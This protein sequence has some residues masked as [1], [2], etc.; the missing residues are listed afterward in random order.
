M[1][2]SGWTTDGKC[3]TARSR[4]G[5]PATF[6]LDGVIA[7]WTEGVQLMVEGEKTRF[8][9]P[10][11][12]AYKGQSAPYGH[13]GVRRRADSKKVQWTFRLGRCSGLR[14]RALVSCS[15]S[16]NQ[17]RSG[18]GCPARSR[19]GKPAPADGGSPQL[20][21]SASVCHRVPL[22]AIPRRT[23][24]SVARLSIRL[25]ETVDGMLRDYS[26]TAHR[27]RR[28]VADD[29]GRASWAR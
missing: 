19:C 13:A 23:P 15:C 4:A 16:C 7:G 5:E 29:D 25:C 26:P 22:R 2:Y 17:A 12:L 8:W 3:S 9:I 24:I 14:A 6:P 20:T 11:Q 18:F 1:H 27:R 10:E 21:N 28:P